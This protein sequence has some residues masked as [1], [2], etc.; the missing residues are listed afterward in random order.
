MGVSTQEFGAVTQWLINVLNI[1]TG[2]L[3]RPGGTMF[4]KPAFDTVAGFGM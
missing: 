1:L 4:T 2:N 3:D